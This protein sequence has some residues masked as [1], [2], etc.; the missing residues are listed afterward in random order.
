[1]IGYELD[2]LRSIPSRRRDFYF[3]HSVQ[4]DSRI[5][6]GYYLMGTASSFAG[7]KAAEAWNWSFTCI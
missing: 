7:S 5:H 2:D 4:T 6:P 1:M 3:R